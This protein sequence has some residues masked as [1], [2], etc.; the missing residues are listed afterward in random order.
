MQ[1]NAGIL[2][3]TFTI[4]PKVFMEE[5]IK[6]E[7]LVSRYEETF[8]QGKSIYFDADQLC[9]IACYYELK[10][11]FMEALKAVSSGLSLHPGHSQLTLLKAKYL[12]FLDCIDESKALLA[13]VTEESEQTTLIR[14]ELS[15]AEG[16]SVEGFAMIEEAMGSQDVD[17]IFCLDIISILWG[18]ATYEQIV[19]YAEKALKMLPDDKDLLLEIGTI[20]LDN[21]QG[22][23]ANIIFNHLLDLDPYQTDIWK[24]Q[25][26]AYASMGEFEKA[27]EACDFALAIQE[28][29]DTLFY[30]GVC[31]YDNEDYQDA[32]ITFEEYG[33]TPDNKNKAYLY[34]ASCYRNLEKTSISI[35]YLKQALE[36]NPKDP[37]IYYHL[38]YN[39]LDMGN[40]PMAK[41]E[42]NNAIG[43]D[44]GNS[45]WY[46]LLGDILMQEENFEEATDIF[47]K[48][49]TLDPAN[50]Y[51]LIA[52]GDCYEK[53]NNFP[54]AVECYEKA[55]HIERYT[56]RVVFR[57]I[58]GYYNIG[59]NDKATAI[60]QEIETVFEELQEKNQ[61]KD[62]NALI[63]TYNWIESLR[64]IVK[65]KL[66]GEE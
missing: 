52:L 29:P 26:R 39:Y 16:K 22:N 11:D 43:L 32:I 50:I 9:D 60:I 57:L 61:L 31:Q 36:M 7:Y 42:I 23:K 64:Q 15:F 6:L 46:A 47:N 59:E 8:G 12:L 35:E 44:G 65:D 27:V 10:E 19:E 34:I 20:Y 41:Q 13:S 62:N 63:E 53:Q 25:A 45:E 17:G 5:E 40:T 56:I 38:A 30:K 48:V 58:M 49:L 28:D 37:E 14:I 3:F 21:N 55:F 4:P 18:Y 51:S 2:W 1:N 54:L 24:E 33:K 66:N